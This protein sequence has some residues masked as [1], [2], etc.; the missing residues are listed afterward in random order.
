MVRNLAG[1]IEV[2]GPDKGDPKTPWLERT[3]SQTRFG[4]A[5][6]WVLNTIKMRARS[7]DGDCE[8]I[9]LGWLRG[10]KFDDIKT[11]GLKCQ[12]LDLERETAE[13]LKCSTDRHVVPVP[14]E[15]LRR[16]GC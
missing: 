15:V 6:G 5:R 12:L 14:D 4:F 2:A 7:V 13:R 8:G 1:V 9:S 11:I 3:F 10:R 16:W